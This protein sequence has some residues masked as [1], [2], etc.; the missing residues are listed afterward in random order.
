MGQIG[1]DKK[2]LFSGAP[3]STAL[4]IV[5]KSQPTKDQKKK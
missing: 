3:V 1:P 2:P 4:T 5:S